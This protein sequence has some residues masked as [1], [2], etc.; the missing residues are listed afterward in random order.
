M[1]TRSSIDPFCS[2][3]ITPMY[4]YQYCLFS[5]SLYLPLRVVKFFFHFFFFKVSIPIGLS[6]PTDQD[7]PF[8]R[9]ADVCIA[10]N[11][12][13]DPFIYVLLRGKCGQWFHCLCDCL[14][15]CGQSVTRES[16]F[17]LQLANDGEAN[18]SSC[19]TKIFFTLLHPTYL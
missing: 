4:L 14:C 5:F 2:Y 19:K 11:F 1:F 7:R 16:S 9:V 17:A 6:N 10:L 12:V 15:P 13:L 18:K 3:S 8:F